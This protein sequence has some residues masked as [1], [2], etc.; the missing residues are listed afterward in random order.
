ARSLFRR[1]KDVHKYLPA[2][3]GQQS[4]QQNV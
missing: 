1:L 4:N 2:R 3:K